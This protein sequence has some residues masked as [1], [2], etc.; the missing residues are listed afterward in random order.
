RNLDERTRRQLR[1]GRHGGRTAEDPLDAA[2]IAEEPLLL[3]D[4]DDRAE[5]VRF[6]G[7]HAGVVV[8]VEEDV[9]REEWEEGRALAAAGLPGVLIE[10]QIVRDRL[11][12]ELAC[13]CLLHPRAGVQNPPTTFA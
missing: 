4:R 7:R 9:P 13:E 1:L 10:R 12:A 11:R 2:E 8:T 3:R 6:K 5:Q